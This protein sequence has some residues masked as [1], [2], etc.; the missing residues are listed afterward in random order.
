MS[1]VKKLDILF[2]KAEEIDFDDNSKIVLISDCHRGDGSFADI[3]SKNQNIYFKALNYYYKEG[4]NYIELGDGDELWGND[5]M[6][7]IIKTYSN[8]FWLLA[9]FHKEGRLNLIYGNHDMV[10]KNDGFVKSNLYERYDEVEERNIEMFNKIK[11]KESIVLR[12]KNNNEKILLI[13][14]H[15]GEF[16]ND[17]LWWVNRFLVRYLWRPLSSFGINDPTSTADNNKKKQIAS[18]GYID[19]V[20]SQKHMLI[21]GHTHKPR[22]SEPYEPAYFN[23]GSCVHPRCITAIEITS[24]QISLVKWSVKVKEDGALYIGKDILAGPKKVRDYMR[25]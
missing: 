5:N 9:K 18:E 11:V 16:M 22:F 12:Y 4:F 20:E 23:T 7:H 13:H 1:T 8:I 14:G 24:G 2:R 17:K 19:W 6:E 25:Y 10:K 3:F 21:A 15:Q